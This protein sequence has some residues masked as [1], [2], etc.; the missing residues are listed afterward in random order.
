[1]NLERAACRALGRGHI[2]LQVYMIPQAAVE[3]TRSKMGSW[4][5][6]T[7]QLRVQ[8]IETNNG[9]VLRRRYSHR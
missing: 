1:M 7:H 2:I 3:C 6:T 4:T 9:R 8:D 5:P